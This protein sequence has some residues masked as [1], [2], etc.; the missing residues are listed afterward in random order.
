MAAGVSDGRSG[1]KPCDPV[2]S[3]RQR[4]EVV[5]ERRR[6]GACA[7]TRLPRPR[8]PAAG[9]LAP[10]L[11]AAADAGGGGTRVTSE[12]ESELCHGYYR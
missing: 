6:P 5:V 8:R 2:A 9:I 1:Y 3:A 7:R 10:A 11:A 4:V 12:S